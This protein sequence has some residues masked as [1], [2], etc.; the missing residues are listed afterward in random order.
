MPY[1]SD[2]YMEASHVDYKEQ[3]EEKNPRSW[4]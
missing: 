3:L 2:L 4:L 1:K